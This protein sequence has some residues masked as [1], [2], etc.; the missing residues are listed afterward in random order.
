MNNAKRPAELKKIRY[1]E[2]QEAYM[3]PVFR[4]FTEKW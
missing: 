1:A 2:E 4:M 3:L